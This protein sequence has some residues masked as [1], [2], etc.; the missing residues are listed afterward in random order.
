MN[1]VE[2]KMSSVMVKQLLSKRK[3]TEAKMN[4]QDF[5]V[6]Y[7]NENYGLL[8]QCVRVIEF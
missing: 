8:R 7:V 3:G 4:P 6:K 5:L 1:T 2:Y